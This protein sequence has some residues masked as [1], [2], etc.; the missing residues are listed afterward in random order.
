MPKQTPVAPV[1]ADEFPLNNLRIVLVSPRNPLNIGAAAR[2]MSNLGFTRLRLVNPYDVAFQGARSA[3][4]AADLLERAEVFETVAEAVHDCSLV[5]GASAVGEREL[6]HPLRRLEQG[7]RVIREHVAASPAALLFGSE[8]YGLGNDDLSHC[9]WLMRIPTRRGH[10]SMNLGQAVAVCLY[11]LVRSP[12]AAVAQPL[13]SK[14]GRAADLERLTQLL[15][16][17][18]RKSGYVKPLHEATTEEK[19]RRLVRRMNLNEQD[20]QVWLGMA[21]Q[22]RWKLE[23]PGSK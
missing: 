11:E 10:G 20:A 21:K 8:K 7:G 15:S 4:G 13:A 18:L 9:H 3:V 23:N 17:L 14:P 16:E 1:E 2:A 6:R 12:R 22:I 19:I 5:V